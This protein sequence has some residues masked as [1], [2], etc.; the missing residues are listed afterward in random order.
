MA[1]ERD[2]E[3]EKRLSDET[4]MALAI[5]AIEERL[6]TLPVKI[7][8]GALATLVGRLVTMS[9]KDDDKRRNNWIVFQRT[10]ENVMRMEEEKVAAEAKIREGIDKQVGEQVGEQHYLANK[11]KG[12]VNG[13]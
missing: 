2:K 11:A 7:A 3:A 13:H 9:H 10:V 12:K 1:E 8:F 5:A 4:R 6:L